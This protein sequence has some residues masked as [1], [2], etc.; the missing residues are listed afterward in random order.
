MKKKPKGEKSKMKITRQANY[1][2]TFGALPLQADVRDY[3][4]NLKPTAGFQFPESFEL[5]HP[6]IKNQGSVGSCV[7]HAVV[8]TAE[9]FHRLQV[10]VYEHLSTG[11]VYGNRRNSLNK[12]SGMYVREAL[13]NMCKCGTPYYGF[14]WENI[15]VPQAIELFERRYDDILEYALPN[16]FSTYFR[17]F[18]DD[19]IKLALMNYGPVVFA[20]NWHDNDY[21]DEHGILRVDT[22]S[23]KVG[24]HCMMI[25]GWNKDGWLIQ[26]SWGTHWGNQGCAILP[27]STKKTEAWGIT[28][29]IIDG[30]EEIKKPYNTTFLRWLAKV[31]NWII[32]LF[33]RKQ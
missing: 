2:K 18:S 8:E 33:R 17:L 3:K 29:E 12:K 19:D 20:M 23:K 4:L 27:Y 13:R 10:G 32:N 7:A 14:F 6:P 15:E 9:Y 30:S 21:V 24:G 31:F 28:D 22:K 25:Y 26:N 16:R 11:F 1:D 5:S